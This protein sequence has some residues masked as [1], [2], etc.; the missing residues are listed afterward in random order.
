TN[1]GGSITA[2]LNAMNSI[3]YTNFS[4]VGYGE[5][6]DT[7]NLYSMIN[8]GL[9]SW[10]WIIDTDPDYCSIPIA[11]LTGPNAVSAGDF[12]PLMFKH[13]DHV[14]TFGKSTAGA[15]GA[16]DPITLPNS[17]YRASKQTSNF[18][19]YTDTSNYL[20]HT[21]YPVNQAT[22]FKR[23]SVCQGSDN[24]LS[25]AVQWIQQQIS[26]SVS[27]TVKEHHFRYYPNPANDV[28][29]VS[30]L[31][32]GHM[33]IINCFGRIILSQAMKANTKTLIPLNAYPNGTYFIRFDTQNNSEIKK[34]MIVH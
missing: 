19:E 16:Y 33:N 3:H 15:F 12:I 20:S 8:T 28:I 23:D 5:R 9:V 6:A 22:W 29:Y 26:T 13:Y 7:S 34:L 25:E 18:F 14:R 11:I 27:T 1:Y 21:S 31:E 30:N 10:Y 4:W 32:N 17:E 24:V 2:F